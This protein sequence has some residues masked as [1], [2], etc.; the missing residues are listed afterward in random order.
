M[1]GGDE[2]GIELQGVFAFRDFDGVA[3]DA[4]IGDFV[5]LFAGAKEDVAGAL[6]FDALQVVDYLI[7]RHDAVADHPGGRATGRRAGG[8]I[9]AGGINAA[10]AKTYGRISGVARDV[11]E[12][13]QDFFS[14]EVGANFLEI[15][16]QRLQCAKA[17]QRDDG[18]WQTRRNGLNRPL[19]ADVG[20]LNTDEGGDGGAVV[21]GAKDRIDLRHFHQKYCRRA[22]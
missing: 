9:F 21:R 7:G 18:K 8:G 13:G 4:D 10:R 6:H 20:W 11:V 12:I 19:L 16:A 3:A 15:G 14:F 2:R 1:P 5:A 17:L 22:R